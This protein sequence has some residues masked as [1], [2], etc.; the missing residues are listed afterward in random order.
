MFLRA[1]FG[2]VQNIDLILK[3]VDVRDIYLQRKSNR[4]QPGYRRHQPIV[5]RDS[6]SNLRF[7]DPCL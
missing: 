3:R 2:N 1:I 5:S 4:L 7:A 6:D